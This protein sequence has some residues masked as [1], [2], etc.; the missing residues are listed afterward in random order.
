MQYVN[1][2]VEISDDPE[3]RPSLNNELQLSWFTQHSKTL[4]H[5]H[6]KEIVH[7]PKREKD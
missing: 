4:T 7:T 6:G 5:C 2:D 3:I 1:H